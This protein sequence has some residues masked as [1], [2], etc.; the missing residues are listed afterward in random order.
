MFIRKV[1]FVTNLWMISAFVFGLSGKWASAL[2]RLR[3]KVCF[4]KNT[5]VFG[6]NEELSLAV[7]TGFTKPCLVFSWSFCFCLLNNIL[8]LSFSLYSLYFEVFCLS[9]FL[10]F[11]FWALSFSINWSELFFAL[12]HRSLHFSAF[13]SPEYPPLIECP[14]TKRN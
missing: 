3:C 1:C 12:S 4:E 11:Q 10:H 7:S 14:N 2:E 5:D 13:L 6:S 9:Y 8:N